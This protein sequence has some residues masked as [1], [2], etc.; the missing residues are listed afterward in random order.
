MRRLPLSSINAG[1]RTLPPRAAHYLAKV[2]RLRGGEVIEVFDPQTGVTAKARVISVSNEVL[3]DIETVHSDAVVAP[4]VLIQGFPKGDKIGDIVRDATELGATMIIP[5]ICERSIA[6]P[7]DE[8]AN[9]RAE[10][11]SAIAAEAARQCGRARAPEIAPPVPWQEA[12]SL[13]RDHAAH[14]FVLWEEASA[15]L[16]KD[17]AAI[18]A[19]TGVAF[20]IGPEGGLTEKEITTAQALG[21]AARSLG[22][23]VLRTET[24]ATAVL[25]AYRV[26][27]P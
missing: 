23:T 14:G 19:A 16:G 22:P 3:I 1:K 7:S 20:A 11:L 27:K 12:I 26:M 10:R 5:A 9:A 17:L 8:R 25:G 6:R 13:A 21:F 4:L 2:L 18:D 24:A 15:P